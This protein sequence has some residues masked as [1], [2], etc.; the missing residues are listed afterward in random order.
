MD[1][2]LPSQVMTPSNSLFQNE[3]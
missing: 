3:V 2:T 1:D